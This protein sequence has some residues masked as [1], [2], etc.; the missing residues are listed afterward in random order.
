MSQQD[1]FSMYDYVQQGRQ[2]RLGTCRPRHLA[3][4]GPCAQRVY[5]RGAL[6][7]S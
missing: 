3:L 6:R 7:A 1:N 4:D 2:V 5:V